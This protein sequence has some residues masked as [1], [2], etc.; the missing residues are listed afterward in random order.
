MP[1]LTRQLWAALRMLLIATVALGVL[2]PMAGLLVATALPAQARGSLIEIDGQAVGSRL[3]GQEY[4]GPGW[5]QLRPSAPEYDALAS[6]ASNLGPNNPDLVELIGERRRTVAAREGVTPPQVPADA[7]TASA[8]GLDPGI[9][10]AYA[11]LQ[12]ARV[13][14]ETGIDPEQLRR[15]IDDATAPSALGALGEVWVNVQDLNLAVAR[16]Q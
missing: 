16:A 8:S 2:Y 4:P 10:P 13:A 6:G 9:S 14:R 5:F 1:A 15:M 7:V 3:I 11:Q 12:A